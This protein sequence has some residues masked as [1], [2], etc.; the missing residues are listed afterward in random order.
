VAGAGRRLAGWSDIEHVFM[1]MNK[2]ETEIRAKVHK[3]TKEQE[4]KWG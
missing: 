1:P 4:E 3:M 2:A